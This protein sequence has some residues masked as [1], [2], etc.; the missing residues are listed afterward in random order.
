MKPDPRHWIAALRTS[1]DRLTALV[2][3]LDDDGLAAQSMCTEW[4]VAR[5]LGHLG[6]G[7]EIGLGILEAHVAGREPPGEEANPPIWDRWNAMEPRETAGSFVGADRRFVEAFEAL[8]EDQLD[9]MRI[10]LPFLPDRI[11]V[12]S[13]VGFRLNEH[14]LHSWDV[15]AAFDPDAT[16]A[17]ESVELLID[18]LPTMVGLIGRFT[19]RATRPA[20]TTAIRITTTGPARELVLVLGDDLELRPATGGDATDGELTIPA[21]ALLRLTAGRLRPDRPS[22][23]LEPAG[24]LS[25]ADLRRAFPG[26]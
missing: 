15:F 11:D 4:S 25:L 18:R 20:E 17:S 8:D 21:E 23:D 26:F 7:A 2:D 22:G 19:P 14:A 9:S 12:A 24:T 1:H 3:G 10:K 16:V 6:S 5:V 13:A